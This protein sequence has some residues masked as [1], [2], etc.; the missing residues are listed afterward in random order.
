[1][2]ILCAKPLNSLWHKRERLLGNYPDCG[3]QMSKI[4]F[5]E[6]LLRYLIK[7]K[8]IGYEVVGQSEEGKDKKVRIGRFPL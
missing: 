4:C 5:Q 3:I 7:W 2:S 1:M 6:L 8:S